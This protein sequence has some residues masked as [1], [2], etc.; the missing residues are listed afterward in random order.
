MDHKFQIPDNVLFDSSK[1][2]ADKNSPFMLRWLAEQMQKNPYNNVGWFLQN[3]SLMDLESLRMGLRSIIPLDIGVV[4]LEEKYQDLSDDKKEKII[5]SR[6]RGSGTVFEKE[7]ASAVF[8]I[9][10]LLT[11]GEGLEWPQKDSN[12]GG[13][14]MALL[15]CY[16]GVACIARM[17]PS[18]TVD[19]N[20]LSLDINIL[21]K[22]ISTLFNFQE[23]E[24][25]PLG[26]GLDTMFYIMTEKLYPE[27]V[28]DW[29]KHG[30]V[31]KGGS[32]TSGEAV[33]KNSEAPKT[34]EEISKLWD[35]L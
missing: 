12:L 13:L 23:G 34:I 8:S 3:C 25:K 9:A 20:K 7:W 33:I 1:I 5:N 4:A 35:T 26:E 10:V 15:T 29:E 27:L 19:Y 14:R 21:T 17:T 22:P 16:V 32:G 6:M 2:V 31:K 30:Y 11:T 18:V 28:K 24:L